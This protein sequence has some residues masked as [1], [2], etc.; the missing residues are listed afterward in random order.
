[1]MNEKEETKLFGYSVE[2]NAKEWGTTVEIIEKHAKEMGMPPEE[3]FLKTLEWERAHKIITENFKKVL[4]YISEAF[5]S[6]HL[7]VRT[8]NYHDSPF[9]KDN[10]VDT[11]NH[12]IIIPLYVIENCHIGD[13]MYEHYINKIIEKIG[14]IQNTAVVAFE[15]YDLSDGIMIY[16]GWLFKDETKSSHAD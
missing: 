9:W 10:I 2:A 8:L 11:H 13:G 1:M 5:Y 16:Y 4:G 7:D 14:D 12:Y 15:G 3:V 6:L